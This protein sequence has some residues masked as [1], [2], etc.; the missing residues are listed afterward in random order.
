M[1]LQDQ[2]AHKVAALQVQLDLQAH[3]APFKALQGLQA[4]LLL[5]QLAQRVRHQLK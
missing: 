3:L 4:L 2:Q 5:D 1:A